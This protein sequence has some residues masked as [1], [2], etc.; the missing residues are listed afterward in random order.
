MHIPL[1]ILSCED[2]DITSDDLIQLLEILA[3]S[4]I[5]CPV[6]CNKLLLW[7]LNNNRIDDRCVSE[8]VRHVPSLFPSLGEG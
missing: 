6:L 5:S 3:K 4:K 1:A 8:L 7:Q 2:C